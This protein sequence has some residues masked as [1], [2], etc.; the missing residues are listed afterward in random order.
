[1][2]ST[3]KLLCYQN[4]TKRN[5][6]NAI[7][8]EMRS[9][10]ALLPKANQNTFNP[11]ILVKRGPT[12]NV[13]LWE[14]FAFWHFFFHLSSAARPVPSSWSGA[15]RWLVQ[16]NHKSNAG[17]YIPQLHG[18]LWCSTTVHRTVGLN[19]QCLLMIALLSAWPPTSSASSWS[20]FFRLGLLKVAKPFRSSSFSL[21]TLPKE[22]LASRDSD[23]NWDS[24][25]IPHPWFVERFQTTPPW[26]RAPL[27]VIGLSLTIMPKPIQP[28]VA[29][30][31]V[32]AEDKISWYHPNLVSG[33]GAYVHRLQYWWW[34]LLW[35]Q[36][37]W[38]LWYENARR[39][40]RRRDEWI[41][42]RLSLVHCFKQIEKMSY[43]KM[44]RFWT[45]KR[46]QKKKH[47]IHINHCALT[48]M[49]TH[50][51][52]CRCHGYLKTWWARQKWKVGPV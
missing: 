23:F 44:P 31:I 12:R 29:K 34:S 51:W 1:M 40:G 52:K 10:F 46:Q 9:T 3:L 22:F 5:Y 43:T 42:K 26:W 20:L 37:R 25:W 2:R 48:K 32:L 50:L 47:T 17:R 24:S 36:I 41:C 19:F 35:P 27:P 11:M 6:W 33:N 8:E 14:M 49:K 16:P 15:I 21:G 7:Q 18:K 28:T 13:V 38:L 39:V 4:Q 30:V 45:V